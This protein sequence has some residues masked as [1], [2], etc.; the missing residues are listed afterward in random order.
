[1]SNATGRSANKT[2]VV[3]SDFSSF[4]V[5]QLKQELKKRGLGAK[6]L[7]SNLVSY[8]YFNGLFI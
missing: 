4:T 7:K 6:G 3:K 2:A 8:Q 5:A 1:M